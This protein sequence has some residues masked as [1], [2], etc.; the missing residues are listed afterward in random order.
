MATLKM[1]MKK[2]LQGVFRLFLILVAIAPLAYAIN[3][4]WPE[5]QRA[6]QDVNWSAMAGSE[7]LLLP[8]M[9]VAGIMPWVS[10]RHLGYSF[11]VLKATCI[12]YFTQIF[13]YLPGGVWA[14]PGRMAVYQLL[15]V[16]S[17]Q[18][19]A[20]VFRETTAMFLGA[21]IV[22]LV[23]LFHGLSLSNN[24][25]LLVGVGILGCIVVI[26]LIQIPG[27]W[28][29]FSSYKLLS[30]SP[31]TAFGE[32]NSEHRNLAWLPPALFGSLVYWLLFGIPFQKMAF[33]VYPQMES[34]TWFE[35]S[36]TYALAWCV[37]SVVVFV[38]AGIGIRESAL[39]LLLTNFMPGGAALSLALLVRAAVILGEGLWVVFTMI[40]YGNEAEFSL[41]VLRRFQREDAED[42]SDH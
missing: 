2:V 20:S 15:G 18:S 34:F 14:F 3:K 36:A 24:L 9:A 29:F 28:K 30:A 35:A 42:E 17:A 32:M 25:R 19:I 40:R 8:V 6:I 37:G 38:P 7:L 22:G 41:G 12:Y 27:F 16:G 26:L 23:G 31:I 39:A 10:L 33:A 1:S 11:S 5:L 21:A 4:E 13:K